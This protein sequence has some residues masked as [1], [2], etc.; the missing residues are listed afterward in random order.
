MNPKPKI[1]VFSVYDEA[2]EDIASVSLFDNFKEYCSLRDYKL[3]VKKIE[4]TEAMSS[5]WH[6]ISTCLEIL[7]TDEFDYVFFMDADCLFI[8]TTKSLE[9]F[10]DDDYFLVCGE[11]YDPITRKPSIISSHLLFKN[12]DESKEFLKEIWDKL[13]SGTIYANKHPWEQHHVNEIA[14]LEKY[15]S[16]IK[17]LKPRKLNSF[18]PQ[19]TPRVVKYFHHCNRESFEVG[20]FTA[21]F[22]GYSLQERYDFMT[23]CNQAL[24]G[25]RIS[26]WRVEKQPR[27]DWGKHEFKFTYETNIV[28]FKSFDVEVTYGPDYL[29]RINNI[30]PK[31]NYGFFF[32]IYTNEDYPYFKITCYDRHVII[33]E[34]IVKNDN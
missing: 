31:I 7:D 21:H 32:V 24:V 12:C 23:E 8:D 13:S 10:I 29:A 20:D 1:C 27:S 26:D 14:K 5:A 3:Q 34:K 28:D 22:C 15:K 25:G 17:I 2:Y 18:W 30:S 9:S 16:G 4:K 33:C 6:K 11:T 19:S